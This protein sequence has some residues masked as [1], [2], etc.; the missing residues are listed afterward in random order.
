M[1]GTVNTSFGRGEQ[2]PGTSWKLAAEDVATVVVNLLEMD[3]RALPSRVELRPS[4]PK[5]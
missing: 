1:P 5:K 3:P 4:E 2:D